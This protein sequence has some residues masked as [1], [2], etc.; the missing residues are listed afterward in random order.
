MPKRKNDLLTAEVQR[1]ICAFITAGTFEHVAAEAAGIPRETYEDWLRLGNPTGRLR[2]GK[3]SQWKPHKLYTPFWYAVLKAKAH[4]RLKAEMA[5]LAEDPVAWLKSGPGK[6]K[7]NDPGWSSSIRPVV[8]ES[9]TQVNV[10]LSPELQG[11]FGSILQVL[12]PFPEAR[13]AVSEALAGSE[14]PGRKVV[15]CLPVGQ[16]DQGGE[17]NA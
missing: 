13:A 17:G 12:A 4:A 16:D 6:D 2:P 14:R 3:R 7:P 8:R 9:N 10:L 5:A 1:N 11:V 15:E